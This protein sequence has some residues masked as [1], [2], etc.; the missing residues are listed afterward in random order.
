[1]NVSWWKRRTFVIEIIQVDI[2]PN[3]LIN[4]SLLT[5][6]S[7]ISFPNSSN[8]KRESVKKRRKEGRKEERGEG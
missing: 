8:P 7:S 1:M 4:L 5:R 6:S 2:T 3:F